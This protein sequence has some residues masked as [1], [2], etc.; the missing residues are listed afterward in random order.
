M[1]VIQ[2]KFILQIIIQKIITLRTI[3][4]QIII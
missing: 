1:I 4:L 2:G 3:T